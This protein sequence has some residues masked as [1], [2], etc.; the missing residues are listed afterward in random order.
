MIEEGGSGRAYMKI[1]YSCVGNATFRKKVSLEIVVTRGN[2]IG[3][4]ITEYP[5]I[6]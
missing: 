5:N 4:A 2:R 3:L 1:L 6:G